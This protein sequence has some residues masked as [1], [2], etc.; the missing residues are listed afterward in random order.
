MIALPKKEKS[1][2]APNT[3]PYPGVGWTSPDATSRV[4][5][6]F[7]QNKIVAN[8][9]YRRQRTAKA[10]AP[11]FVPPFSHPPPHLITSSGL[12]RKHSG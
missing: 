2:D 9:V 4:V 12:T 3:P 6:R 1:V 10:G 8:D 11:E 5:S 7:E